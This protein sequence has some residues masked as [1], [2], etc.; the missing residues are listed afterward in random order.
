MAFRWTT[1]RIIII[2]NESIVVLHE[3][4]DDQIRVLDQSGYFVTNV[5]K[6]GR[7]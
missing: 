1:K 5:A 3:V 4:T 7:K 6:K 2:N